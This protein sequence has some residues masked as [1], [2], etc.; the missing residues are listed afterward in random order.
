MQLRATLASV[1]SAGFVSV[2]ACGARTGLDGPGA[3]RATGADS[4]IEDA[5]LDAEPDS[6]LDASV[7]QDASMGAICTVS[8]DSGTPAICASWRAGGEQVVSGSPVPGQTSYFT[9]AVAAGDGILCA[10][11]TLTGANEST[12]ITRRIGFDGVPQGPPRSHL[13]FGTSAGVDVDVMSLAGAGCAFGGLV[14]DPVNG[15]RF[16]PLDGEGNEV[17]PA[18]AVQ[19]LNGPPTGPCFDLGADSAGE[20]TLLFGPNSSDP[21]LWLDLVGHGAGALLPSATVGLSP[22]LVFGD[23]S[24]LLSTFT[25]VDSGALATDMRHFAS[26]GTLLAGPFTLSDTAYSILYMTETSTGVLAAYQGA[27]NEKESVIVVPLDHDGRP[28]AAPVPVVASEYPA[29][30]GEAIGSAPGGDAIVA[31]QSLQPDSTF[32]LEV[33]ALAPDGSPRGAPTTIGTYDAIGTIRIVESVD[34]TRGVL[35]FTAAE[36]SLPDGMRAVPLSCVP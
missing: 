13:S 31:W 14:D 20:F 5:G 9:S 28:T 16:L 1:C 6:A 8:L 21:R 3:A 35:L 34:G 12:W 2:M 27:A 32:K 10:W 23:G 33:Q 17:G 11:F 36:S 15:C 7:L 25:E 29:L 19:S 4:G 18:Q 24:F 26:D 22:R 30:Y